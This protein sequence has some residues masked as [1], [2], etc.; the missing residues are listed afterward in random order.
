MATVRSLIRLH[1][2]EESFSV[3]GFAARKPGLG[4]RR[5]VPLCSS[6][7]FSRLRRVSSARFAVVS[8]RSPL[9]RSRSAC[10]TQYRIDQFGVCRRAF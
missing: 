8:P 6:L 5:D 10:F 7:R 3:A 2:F 4:F 9:T 1:E